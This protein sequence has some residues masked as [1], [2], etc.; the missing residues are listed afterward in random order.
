MSQCTHRSFC[1]V[2]SCFCEMP[3]YGLLSSKRCVLETQIYL[4]VYI[5][6]PFTL[7]DT[8]C[9]TYIYRVH[10]DVSVHIMDRFLR[11]H[12]NNVRTTL[13]L[14]TLKPVT[15]SCSWIKNLR[16][17]IKVKIYLPFLKIDVSIN[18]LIH[19][20][21]K[22]SLRAPSAENKTASNTDIVLPSH[23]LWNEIILWLYLN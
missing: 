13:S 7:I 5:F 11:F 23:S 21:Q 2:L 1:C 20:F 9:C 4:F 17:A 14:V 15:N 10:C 6:F 8:W 19:S 22:C 16:K 18:S 3:Y 12:F